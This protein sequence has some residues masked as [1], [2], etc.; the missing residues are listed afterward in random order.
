MNTQSVPPGHPQSSE[1][2]LTLH[3]FRY[4][5]S[6]WLLAIVT[7]AL[8]VVPCYWHR[9]IEAG[10]LPSHTYNAWLAHLIGQGQAPGLYIV[11]QWNN[12][13]LDLALLHL[14][15][16]VGFITA[17][18]I[19]AAV[20]VLVFFWGTFAFIAAATQRAPWFL[21]SAIAMI[22][23][24]YTFYMGFLN[25]Y[26]SLGLGF[27][28]V[29]LFWRGTRWDWI[30]GAVLVVFTFLAHPMGLACLLGTAAYV[31]LAEKLHGIYRWLLFASAF[32]AVYGAHAF[33]SRRYRSFT[34]HDKTDFFT[35]NGADQLSLFGPRYIKLEWTVFIMGCLIFL[36]GVWLKRNTNTSWKIFRAPLELWAALV[37]AAL[38]FPEII[39]LP[40]YG[41]GSVFGF[42]VS[43]LTTV[44]AVFGLCVL[45]S[46]E[47]NKWHFLV[48]SAFAI[49]FFVFQ[50]QDTAALNRMEQQAERLVAPLPYGH[51]VMQT[52]WPGD[53]SRIWFIGHM[54]ERACIGKCFLYSNYEA[55]TLQF[56]IRAL[57]GNP[58]VTPSS[59]DSLHMEQGRYT[60][61][62][63]DLP[64]SQ[65]YQCDEADLTKLCIRDLVA[66]EVNGRLGHLP[67]K[68]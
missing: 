58:I 42:V 39:F 66:G 32:P 46:I 8:L 67:P 55:G 56:R 64:I 25:Y 10:D 38:V 11:P 44:T 13:L 9:R 29:A 27:F 3:A 21:V 31:L 2:S 61:R 19:V 24:G 28:A 26:L 23:Y 63:E 45:G 51:R 7:S 20:C 57:P 40:Q 1:S 62:P 36:L 54:A 50:Y 33:I 59:K 52:M 30:G 12:A 5:C 35:M 68:F 14:G 4:L 37:F 17:E 41:E 15:N 43:R 60:V 34:W 47:L 16:A 6:R 18:K 49:V 53:D 48:L 65:I 22:A